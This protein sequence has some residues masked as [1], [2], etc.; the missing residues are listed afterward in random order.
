VAAY[1]EP[2]NFR[3]VEPPYC[4]VVYADPDGIQVFGSGELLKIKAL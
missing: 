1:E 2:N 3:F 4:A